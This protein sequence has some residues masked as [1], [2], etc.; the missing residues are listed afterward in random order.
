MTNR[1]SQDL[2]TVVVH[3]YNQED[4]IAECLDGIISQDL[5]PEVRIL[6]IDDCSSD[7]T[8]EI[9]LSYRNKYPNQIDIVSNSYNQLSQGGLIGL[10]AYTR[11]MS[12][13]IAWCDGDDY[14]T[15]KRKLN[16]QVAL[17][18]ENIGISIVHTE[19]RLLFQNN[20]DSKIQNRSRSQIERARKQRSGKD[21]IKGNHVK[22]S[23]AVIVRNRIDLDFLRRASGIYV[24]DWLI[25][26]SATREGSVEFLPEATTVVRITN[27]GMWNGSS[28]ARNS[29]QKDRIKWF[30]AA[31][32]PDSPLRTDFRRAVVIGWL[33]NEVSSSAIYKVIRPLVLTTR[34]ARTILLKRITD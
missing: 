34:K 20:S 23:T 17:L 4:F 31:N 2:I 25:C 9:C 18:E 3:T 22:H 29:D 6:V 26:I 30:C 14:W 5:F 7:S 10:N 33:R 8:R 19:Y 27:S 12:K 13:Y 16:K 28:I 15:D 24:G 11:I 32:L 21:F 1:Q